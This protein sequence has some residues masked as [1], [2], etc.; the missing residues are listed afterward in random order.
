[1]QRLNFDIF[2]LCA[3]KVRARF[4]DTIVLLEKDDF[5]LFKMGC[6]CSVRF[7]G[8]KEP[9]KRNFIHSLFWLSHN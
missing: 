4:L 8:P 1:M 9:I 2:D 5:G 7:C 3:S 6:N